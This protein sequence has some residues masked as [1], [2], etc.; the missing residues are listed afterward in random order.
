MTESASNEIA[1]LP[2]E[3]I[4]PFMEGR[5]K[6]IQ[7]KRGYRFSIN[8]LLLAD[9]VTIR[10]HDIV[11]DLGTGCGVI[12]LSMLVTKPAKHIYC[13]EIQEALA[14]QAM[15]NAK[16][17]NLENRMSVIMGDIRNPPL[18]ASSANVVVC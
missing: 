3:T 10:K 14:S 11:V 15:R 6:I 13:I 18:F 16:L 5:L 2:G 7:S 8:A 1:P 9:F 4:D 17:N 12:P